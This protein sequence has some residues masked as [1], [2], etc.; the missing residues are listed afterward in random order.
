MSFSHFSDPRMSLNETHQTRLVSGGNL[1]IVVPLPRGFSLW[2]LSFV[3]PSVPFSVFVI[4]LTLDTKTSQIFN[5]PIFNNFEFAGENIPE[6]IQKQYLG[7]TTILGY[8]FLISH[9]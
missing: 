4:A 1:S 6:I 7:G 2:F 5:N 8:S 3:C 9:F